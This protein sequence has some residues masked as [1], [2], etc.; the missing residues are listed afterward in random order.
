MLL[1]PIKQMRLPARSVIPV[2]LISSITPNGVQ[3]SK[4]GWWFLSAIQPTLKGC[5]PSTSFAGGINL[6]T[7]ARSKWAGRGNWMMTPETFQ[8]TR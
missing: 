8:F 5:S 7:R 6:S 3:D 4:N 1:L 2:L